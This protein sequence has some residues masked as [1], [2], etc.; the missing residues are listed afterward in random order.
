M[1]SRLLKHQHRE[2]ILKLYEIVDKSSIDLK[3]GVWEDWIKICE[4]EK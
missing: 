4:Q 1:P 3:I 2:I